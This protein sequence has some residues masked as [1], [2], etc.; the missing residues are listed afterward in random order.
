[1]SPEQAALVTLLRILTARLDHLESRTWR[2]EPWPT[3]QVQ[4]ALERLEAPGQAQAQASTLPAQASMQAPEQ[5]GALADILARLERLEAAPEADPLSEGAS[6]CREVTWLGQLEARIAALEARPVLEPA[7]VEAVP[8]PEDQMSALA[9]IAAR[10]EAAARADTVP[11][12]IEA[13][14]ARLGAIEAALS[15][16]PTPQGSGLPGDAAALARRLA[17][18][19]QRIDRLETAAA[20][21]YHHH[22][23]PRRLRA[24]ICEILVALPGQPTAQDVLG[25][26]HRQGMHPLPAKRTVQW[27][28][29]ALKAPQ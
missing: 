11:A 6:K 5:P 9:R 3:V 1:M 29:K 21:R 8:L 20:A 16:I 10:L 7:P 22:S 18:Q 26:L 4:A 15:V 14:A 12:D 28:M 25:E 27:H 23:R 17:E 13:L 24:A 19:Q 2:R